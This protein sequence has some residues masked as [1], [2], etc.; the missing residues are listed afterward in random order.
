MKLKINKETV[1]AIITAIMLAAATIT[2][3]ISMHQLNKSIDKYIDQRVEVI[4]K[5]NIN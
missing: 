1:K 4:V 5:K 3:C 2:L